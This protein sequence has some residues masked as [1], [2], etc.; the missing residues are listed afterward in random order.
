MIGYIL[1]TDDKDAMI[2]T[3]AGV[4][5]TYID[6]NEIERW[7]A[8]NQCRFFLITAITRHK[9]TDD[10]D[11]ENSVITTP[12]LVKNGFGYYCMPAR[13]LRRLKL[14]TSLNIVAIPKWANLRHIA[15]A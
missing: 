2:S 9:V 12:R 11:P 4:S 5:M 13:L 1:K 6:D 10:N 3:L 14:W 8:P 7:I 15:R